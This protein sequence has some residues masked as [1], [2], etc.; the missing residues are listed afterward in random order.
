MRLSL[1]KGELASRIPILI[2]ILASLVVRAHSITIEGRL[3]G[4]A[5][6][7]FGQLAYHRPEQTSTV[8]C[9]WT[10]RSTLSKPY[11]AI[12]GSV[13][14]YAGSGKEIYGN[15]LRGWSFWDCRGSRVA[16]LVGKQVP[17]NWCRTAVLSPVL[18]GNHCITN[19][20]CPHSVISRQ[21]ISIAG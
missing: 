2:F 18:G 9:H 5:L 6:P 21:L 12:R 11:K 3:R 20:I 7:D 17:G 15:M 16:D 13:R 1:N 4:T 14:I 8:L 19:Q 10:K